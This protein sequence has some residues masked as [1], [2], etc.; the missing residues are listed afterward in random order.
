MHL[1]LT[2]GGNTSQLYCE[3]EDTTLQETQCH[4]G[5]GWEQQARYRNKAWMSGTNMTSKGGRYRGVFVWDHA[6]ATKK[7]VKWMLWVVLFGCKDGV[8]HAGTRC[9]IA[10]R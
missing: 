10:I 4:K 7:K 8:P 3:C 9:V 1:D 6:E 5:W 2:T